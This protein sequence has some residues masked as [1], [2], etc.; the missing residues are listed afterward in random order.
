MR[1][2]KTVIPLPATFVVILFT[3]LTVA[4]LTASAT[5]ADQWLIVNTPDF[6]WLRCDPVSPPNGCERLVLRGDRDKE[7]SDLFLRVPKG[8]LFPKHWHDNAENLVEISGTLVI[9]SEGG[10]DEVVLPGGYLRI[11]A[12]LV[13]WG[14]CLDGCLFYLGVVG[15]DSYHEVK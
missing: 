14:K 9:A 15:A 4:L 8:F 1:L 5:A 2:P 11:P 7:A 3:G 10:R 6:K 13:H 12:K